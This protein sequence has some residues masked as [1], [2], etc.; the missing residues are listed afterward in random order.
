MS[1]ALETKD[2]PLEEY[3]PE[4]AA[5]PGNTTV[6]QRVL[7][8][9]DRVRIWDIDL[10]AGDRLPFHCH[11]ST[12][13]WICAEAGRGN[14]RYPNGKMDTFDFERGEVDFLSI[15]KGE[16]LIHDLENA[17]DAPLRFFAVELLDA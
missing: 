2:F 3:G 10:A 16:S 8:E 13:F 11:T 5:A 7:F 4:L 14:Q 9:N 15:A 1:A 12:Y 17:G 6:G